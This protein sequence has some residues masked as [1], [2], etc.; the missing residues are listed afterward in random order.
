[1]ERHIKLWYFINT[2]ED[3]SFLSTVCPFP[4]S[5]PLSPIPASHSSH[6][7]Y[8]ATHW[9]VCELTGAHSPKE[10]WLSHFQ[11]ASTVNCSSGRGG[12]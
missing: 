10:N 6:H 4:L 8:G 12:D 5:S 3:G 2:F 7:R 1:M 9:S 11:K